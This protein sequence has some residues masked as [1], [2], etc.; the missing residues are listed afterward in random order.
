MQL[1]ATRRAVILASLVGVAVLLPALPVFAAT[2]SAA[3]PSS[4]Y[5]SREASD[6][7]VLTVLVYRYSGAPV[8]A[9]FSNGQYD[10]TATAAGFFY[11]V[12]SAPATVT[13]EADAWHISYNALPGYSHL[14]AVMETGQTFYL[15]PCTAAPVYVAVANGT[16]PGTM[17]VAPYT[18]AVWQTYSTSTATMSVTGTVPV[19]WW[20]GFTLESGVPGGLFALLMLYSGCVV[21]WVVSRG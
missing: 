20:T 10:E 15:G 16:A 8:G 1:R 13:M 9:Q 6:P 12:R 19:D 21:G 7:A 2:F 14:I 17:T 3:T 18:G 5:V 4:L 11:G